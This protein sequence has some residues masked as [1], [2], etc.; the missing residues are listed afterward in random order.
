MT[1]RQKTD[2]EEPVGV[3]RRK[4]PERAADIEVSKRDAPSGFIFAQQQVRNQKSTDDEE[5]KDTKARRN[6][7][8]A[9]MVVHNDPRADGSEKIEPRYARACERAYSDRRIA[10]PV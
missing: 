7:Q 8:V 4:D 6:T 2:G 1:K 3:K 10:R 9:A 5:G